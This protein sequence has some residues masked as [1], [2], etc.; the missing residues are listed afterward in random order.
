M[1]KVKIL[2]V[3]DNNEKLVNLQPVIN[4]SNV[5]LDTA[6]S[7]SEAKS[8]LSDIQFHVLLVDIQV[9][10][11][12]GLEPNPEGGISLIEWIEL[13]QECHRPYRVLGIT[14]ASASKDIYSTFFEERGCQLFYS[15]VGDLRWVNVVSNMVDYFSS[16]KPAVVDL[17]TFDL[18]FITALR[19][20]E[21][22]AVMNLPL[23]WIRFSLEDD[24]MEYYKGTLQT[25][26]GVKNILACCSGRMGLSQT[27]SVT[28][29]IISKFNPSF[30]IMTGISAGIRSKTNLG[31][32]L[33]ADV[34]WDWGSGKLEKNEL[35]TLF[36]P[37]PHQVSIPE[38]LLQKMHRMRDETPHVDAIS[39]SWLGPK[40]QNAIKIVIGPVASGSVVLANSD[41]LKG[42]LSFNRTTVGVEMEA[43]GFMLA[44]SN[45]RRRGT[46]ALV[47]KSVCDFGDENKSDDWQDFCCHMSTQF[48]YK[49]VVDELFGS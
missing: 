27:S 34:V 41:T 8:K 24:P 10:D 40:P 46:P 16:G 37:A 49:F 1:S 11:Q 43:Y 15:S 19:H 5:E 9:P 29:K 25:A 45:T 42:I 36:L 23:N 4:D 33:V 18:A 48:A 3:E 31:D 12:I 39:R 32:V 30:M 44:C 28:S 6:R 21:F 38:E 14:G 20:N 13:S 2:I 47:I 26:T 17:E 35:E 22:R 7:I